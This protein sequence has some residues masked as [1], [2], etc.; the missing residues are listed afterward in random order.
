VLEPVEPYFSPRGKKGTPAQVLAPFDPLEEGLDSDSDDPSNPARHRPFAAAALTPALLAA[1][2]VP[3]RWVAAHVLLLRI[4]GAP[5]IDAGSPRFGRGPPVVQSLGDAAWVYTNDGLRVELKRVSPDYDWTD[6][7]SDGAYWRVTPCVGTADRAQLPAIR[8]Q[9]HRRL[10]VQVA[11]VPCW[12]LAG[13]AVVLP[14]SWPVVG[15]CHR[16]RASRRLKRKHC[17]TCGY[18]LRATPDRCPECGG[19]RTATVGRRVK[20]IGQSLP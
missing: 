8:D 15:A 5:Y 9:W 10:D 12:A 16:K 1:L 19:N 3:A 6:D 2:E 7:E 17:P 14:I 11:S 4:H 20:L 13:A 18:D